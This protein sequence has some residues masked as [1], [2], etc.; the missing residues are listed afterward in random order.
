MAENTLGG[1]ITLDISEFSKAINEANRL[2]R[3][4][5]SQWRL[6]ASTMGDWTKSEE[7]LTSRM[8]VLN[9]QIK[10]Q[11]GILGQLEGKKRELIEAYGAES[12]EVEA[13]NKDIARYGKALDA[14]Y[15][16]QNQVKKSLDSLTSSEDKSDKTKKESTKTTASQTKALSEQTDVLKKLEKSV[17]NV[18]S[19]FTVM[20]GVIANLVA[21]SLKSIVSSF[22]SFVN[23]IDTLPS[24][25]EQT[26]QKLGQ[27]QNSFKAFG[28]DVKTARKAYVDFTAVLGSVTSDT[29]TALSLMASLSETTKDLSQWTTTL[30]G[31]YAKL[32]NT[33]PTQELLKN[34]SET[35][36]TG[37]MTENLTKALTSAGVSSS[38]FAKK[39]EECTSESERLELIQRTLFELYGDAGRQY[40]ETNKQLIDARR[41][42]EDYQIAL[43]RFGSALEPVKT[44]FTNAKTDILNALADLLEGVDGADAEL[45]YTIGYFLGSVAKSLRRLKDVLTPI[46]DNVKSSLASWWSDNKEP[47]K[48][49]VLD[50][51]KDIFNLDEGKVGAILK[52]GLIASIVAGLVGGKSLLLGAGAVLLGYIF[53]GLNEGK[54][55]GELATDFA[56]ALGDSLEKAIKLINIDVWQALFG[57]RS[58]AE[59][60]AKIRLDAQNKADVFAKAFNKALEDGLDFNTAFENA[61]KE[62]DVDNDLLEAIKENLI[63]VAKTGLTI[64]SPFKVDIVLDPQVD[65]EDIKADVKAQLADALPPKM[66]ASD[67]SQENLDFMAKAM[68]DL[69]ATAWAKGV[70]DFSGSD[71]AISNTTLALKNL[72]TKTKDDMKNDIGFKEACKNIASVIAETVKLGW[73]AVK[74]GIG[75]F[76]TWLTGGGIKEDAATVTK[77]TYKPQAKQT[78]LTRGD[79][80]ITE[81]GRSASIDKGTVL[82]NIQERT[83][84]VKTGV[85]QLVQDATEGAESD[86]VGIISTNVGDAF[87]EGWEDG[88]NGNQSKMRKEVVAT[89]EDVADATEG[90]ATGHWYDW[91]VKVGKGALKGLE[92][93]SSFIGKAITDVFGKINSETTYTDLSSSIM[94]SLISA[95]GATGA[96]GKVISTL[97]GIGKQTLDMDDGELN[98]WSENITQLIVNALAQTVK[99]LPKL[100]R[101]AIAFMKSFGKAMVDALP[102]LLGELPVIVQDIIQELLN[103]LPDFLDIGVQMIKGLVQGMWNAIKNIG[104]AIADIGGWILKGFKSI[105]GI[106]SPSKVFANEIGKNI[107]LGIAK[108]ISDNV[109]AINGTLDDVQTSI[110]MHGV[111]GASGGNTMVVNQY[112]NYSREHSRYELYR[113]KKDIAN[114]V[115]VAMGV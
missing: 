44:E 3:E 18:S 104:K 38:E 4:N 32:G 47:L 83:D 51:I 59:E 54:T 45:S 1:R 103:S 111:A 62:I 93:V 20:K 58:N 91:F 92:A 33:F 53:S 57:N 112:N 63:S 50:G 30:T 94:D 61:A 23:I 19:G 10:Q 106:A 90:E 114:A 26:R 66:T 65:T 31:I 15:K 5:E 39:L 11:Q 41:A 79:R 34:I 88:L 87:V 28:F 108:G 67:F 102:W 52:G 99:D 89:V 71:T 16:E 97:L 96:G 55:L 109:S 6:S 48:E 81:L 115:K 24:A 75:N 82:R 105:F 49:K 56:T 80:Q 9:A 64:D 17:A 29:S 21:S 113:S 69:N 12:K 60:N 8:D 2:I 84:E 13:V 27:L 35:S 22:K 100:A 77:E 78:L 98:E 107:S 7:G 86:I 110:D 70:A 95:V 72:L 76:W 36:K 46:W 42:T 40:E 68:E 37:K 74:S 73:E 101:G 25:T 85:V 43:S 14:S